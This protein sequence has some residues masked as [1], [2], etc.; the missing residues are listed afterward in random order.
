MLFI[1]II[2]LMLPGI[3]EIQKYQ[4]YH[5]IIRGIP[6]EIKAKGLNDAYDKARN[7]YRAIGISQ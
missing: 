6:I 5:F 2:L 4:Y 3:N 7:W 1:L